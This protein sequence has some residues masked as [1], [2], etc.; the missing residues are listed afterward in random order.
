MLAR[1]CSF[2]IFQFV[3]AVIAAIFDDVAS[4]AR[5][6]KVGS[7]AAVACILLLLRLHLICKRVSEELAM[8]AIME[9][10]SEKYRSAYRLYMQ[11]LEYII[12]MYV[13][14]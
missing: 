9:F 2:F 12:H 4:C 7:F 5:Q 10:C 8:G 11:T 13:G 3:I 14:L 1:F 6:Q